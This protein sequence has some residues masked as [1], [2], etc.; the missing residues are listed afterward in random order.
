MD[1]RTGWGGRESLKRGQREG[2][3]TGKGCAGVI[4][5]LQ[6]SALDGRSVGEV[7]PVL[8]FQR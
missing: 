7:W 8:G 5:R 2:A 6:G 4:A 3:A 1:G